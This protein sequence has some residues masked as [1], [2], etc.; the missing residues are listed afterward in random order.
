M[1][2]PRGSEYSARTVRGVSR[3]VA[4]TGQVGVW[5]VVGSIGGIVAFY[6]ALFV[7]FPLTMLI[8]LVLGWVFHIQ[9]QPLTTALLTLVYQGAIAVSALCAAGA[10]PAFVAAWLLGVRPLRRRR[11]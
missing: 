6:A 4:L 1:G 10:A 2:K 9:Q 3:V 8:D 5:A 7:V 11:R